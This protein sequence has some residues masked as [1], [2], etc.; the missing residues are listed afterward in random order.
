MKKTEAVWLSFLATFC[1]LAAVSSWAYTYPEKPLVANFS[2]AIITDETVETNET[3][4][5]VSVVSNFPTI[6]TTNE[7]YYLVLI[8][9]AD[10]A[11]EIV[12][13]DSVDSGTKT[14]FVQRAQDDTQALEFSRNDR[15]EMW[16]T[17]GL[18]NDWRNYIFNKTS[19]TCVETTNT[20]FGMIADFS[21][22]VSNMITTTTNWVADEQQETRDYVDS[23]VSSV[24]VFPGIVTPF[25]GTNAPSGWLECDGSAISRTTYSN[26]FAVVGTTFGAGDTNTTFNIPDLRGEFVRGWDNG[27]GVDIGRDF[28]SNQSYA[29]EDHTHSLP[30][31]WRTATGIYVGSGGTRRYIE[32]TESGSYGENETRPRNVA[33]MYIIK[34]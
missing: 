18:M 5:I 4:I 11:R 26:L 3:A 21:T 1:I 7:Y 17:A 22:Y 20:V 27:A 34:Y 13:V 32:A 25:A 14:L 33:L 24:T 6:G 16:L 15:V 10:N 23:Q 28:G 19:N 31:V 12:R 8:R 9:T 2:R 30:N 29:V